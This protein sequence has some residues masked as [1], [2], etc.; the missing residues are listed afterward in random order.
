MGHI[1]LFPLPREMGNGHTTQARNKE[2]PSSRRQNQ[3]PYIIFYLCLKGRVTERMKPREIFHL[4]AHSPNADTNQGRATLYARDTDS[5]WVFHMDGRKPSTWAT[6]CGHSG[7][8]RRSWMRSRGRTQS[9]ILQHGMQTP[10]V[11]A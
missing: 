8:F 7:A 5:S 3:L 6:I 10:A 4:L 1:L 2:I 11:A 9:K